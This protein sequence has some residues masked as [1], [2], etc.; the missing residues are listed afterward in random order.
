MERE[1]PGR[2]GYQ[3]ETICRLPGGIE[4]YWLAV[5]DGTVVGFARTGTADAAIL[6]SCAN[7]AGRWGNRYGGLGPIGV[8]EDVRGDGIGS[9][10]VASVMDAFRRDGRRHMTIDGVAPDLLDFYAELGFGPEI[11][12]RALLNDRE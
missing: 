9:F 10:L 5:R 12:F 8:S 3:V 1:F 6:S 7:W 4:D 2:W 11:E